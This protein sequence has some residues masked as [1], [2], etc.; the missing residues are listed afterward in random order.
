MFM[1]AP[2]INIY[3]TRGAVPTSLNMGKSQMQFPTLVLMINAVAL[4]S[5][6][7]GIKLLPIEYE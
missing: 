3:S 7:T 4:P 5:K 1:D 2:R 6:K